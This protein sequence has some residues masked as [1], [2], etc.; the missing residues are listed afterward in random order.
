MSYRNAWAWVDPGYGLV[1][2]ILYLLVGDVEVA[3]MAVSLL[4]YLFLITLSYFAISC[5]LGKDAAFFASLFIITWPIFFPYSYCNYTE[6]LYITL[7]FASFVIFDF[8][9]KAGS[10][11]MK[12]IL[13]GVT[14]GMA[15]LVRVEGA[16]V[17]A[18]LVCLLGC[19]ALWHRFAVLGGKLSGI[20][21]IHIAHVMIA[22]SIVLGF[23]A[24]VSGMI[25]AESGEWAISP[26]MLA[27]RSLGTSPVTEINLDQAKNGSSAK[28]SSKRQAAYSQAFGRISWKRS[29]ENVQNIM[30]KTVRLTWHALV[31]V[32]CLWL[33]FPIIGKK[34]LWEVRDSGNSQGVIL[35]GCVLLLMP[36]LIYVVFWVQV[37]YLMHYLLFF[38][39]LMGVLTAR[40]LQHMP[41][42]LVG[43]NLGIGKFLV[44]GVAV[45]AAMGYGWDV[46]WVAKRFSWHR[47]RTLYHAVHDRHAHLGS[48]LAG[49]WIA[50]QTK[51]EKKPAIA[52]TGKGAVTLFYA[53]GKE[54]PEGKYWGLSKDTDPADIATVMKQYGLQYLVMDAHYR[55]TVP[56]LLEIWE[57][58]EKA[59]YFGLKLAYRDENGFCQVYVPE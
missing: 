15:Y 9:V 58:P 40:L 32:F 11:T 35:V 1:S 6:S 26:K 44:A 22:V 13:L 46:W 17:A 48:R 39:V 55:H 5:L 42:R 59:K 38:L 27:R 7:I 14:L 3:G 49:L 50:K 20:R 52:T 2:Y 31:P 18:L 36:L 28:V 23:V 51:N 53:N 25:Y 45:I 24:A 54:W 10:T 16:V 37:R 33:L 30:E 47:P 56:G 34:P 43:R 21:S 19:L 57:K 41:R 8:T 12:G 29:A 4:S